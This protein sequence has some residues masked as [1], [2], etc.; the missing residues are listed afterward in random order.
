MK[1]PENFQKN[2]SAAY[3]LLGSIVGLGGIGYWLSIKY[4]NKYL[5]ILLLLIGVM[6]GMYELYKIIKQ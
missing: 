2:I 3:T 5:F 4:D 1:L 6:A